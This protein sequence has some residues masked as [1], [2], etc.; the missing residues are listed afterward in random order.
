MI[1]VIEIINRV[2]LT[3]S[4]NEKE[5]ILRK[6]SDNVDLKQAVFLAYDQ[7]TQFYIRKIPKYKPN[8]DSSKQPW[9]LQDAFNGLKGLSERKFTGNAGVEHLTK[10]LENVSNQDALVIMLI[11]GKDL[12]CGA[13]EATF[14]KIWPD[15]VKTYPIMKASQFDKKLIER[16]I[17]WP[18][19]VQLKMDGMRGNIH[20]KRNKEILAY[21]PSGKDLFFHRIVEEAA[22]AW[23]D[24][25]GAFPCVID[26]EFYCVKNGKILPRKEGNGICNKAIRGTISEEE[27]SW[28]RFKVWDVIPLEDWEKK[29]CEIPY[30]ERYGF[31]L[32]ADR[33]LHET[34]AY[35]KESQYNP[36]S[37]LATEMVNSLEEAVEIFQRF[38]KAGEEGIILKDMEGVWEDTRAKDQIKFKNALQ[39]ELRVKGWKP[40]T[41]GTKYEG[42]LGSLECYSEDDIIKVNISWFTDEERAKGPEFYMNKIVTVEYNS[43]I[44][45][46]KG[47][48]SLFIPGFIEVRDDKNIAQ[49]EDTIPYI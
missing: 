17:T 42:M 13:S 19:G 21:S 6:Y 41:P 7:F 15:L 26:G 1:E 37:V 11:I 34:G 30:K 20:L 38:L 22:R 9:T 27:A 40:G 47:E 44:I 12:K 25:L 10:I 3:S 18:A 29:L 33:I 45:N 23:F 5:E 14:N 35:Y 2:A 39:C 48:H 16:F 43:R 4:R 49:T 36:I 46:E 31:I 8:F 28:I 32:Q 24:A